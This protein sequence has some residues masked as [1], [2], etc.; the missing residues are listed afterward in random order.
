M[1]SK[2]V[3]FRDK[4]ARRIKADEAEDLVIAGKAQYISNTVYKAVKLGV[5]IDAI[6]NRRDDKAI[7]LQMKQLRIEGTQSV[8][9]A[10]EDRLSRGERKQRRWEAMA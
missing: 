7:R 5:S 10:Q 1:R 6:R 4:T 3:L 8:S 9:P 2:N